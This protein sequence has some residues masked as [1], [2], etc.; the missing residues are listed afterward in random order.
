MESDRIR[1]LHSPIQEPVSTFRETASTLAEH[2]MNPQ[3]LVLRDR[4]RPFSVSPFLRIRWAHFQERLRTTILFSGRALA[5]PYRDCCEKHA[6]RAQASREG[7]F[8]PP[9]RVRSAL[10]L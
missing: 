7:V 1:F 4:G 5:A 9:A 6:P 3:V 10:Q 2:S 8:P